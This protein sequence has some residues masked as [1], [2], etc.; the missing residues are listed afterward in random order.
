MT[1]FLTIPGEHL[2]DMLNESATYDD[3][4]NNITQEF[5]ETRKRQHATNEVNVREI[6]YIPVRTT[7]EGGAL[8]LAST[9]SNYYSPMYTSPKK[10][11][12]ITSHSERRMEQNITCNPSH[13][14][15]IEYG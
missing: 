3:L 8:Q 5:P 9:S 7:A 10:M 12:M 11:L 2:A 4:F 15:V 14:M 6:R 13:W 1:D